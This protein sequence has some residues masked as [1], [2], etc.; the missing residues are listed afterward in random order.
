VAVTPV[1]ASADASIEENAGDDGCDKALSAEEIDSILGTSVEIKGSGQVCQYIFASDS[2]G[3][4]Q[5]FTGSKADEAMDVVLGKF[6][7]DE[8]AVARGV[9]LADDRGYV[10][11]DGALV[12]GDSGQ[13]FSLGIPDNI[14]VADKLVAIQLIADLLLTR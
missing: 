10:D 1:E 14:D 5:A 12:L 13:V 9:V 8:T 4:L 3:T 6:L 11:P 2:I 7:A